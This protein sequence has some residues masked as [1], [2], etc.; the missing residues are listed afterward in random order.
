MGTRDGPS[1]VSEEGG[2]SLIAAT[3]KRA[4]EMGKFDRDR[5]LSDA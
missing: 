3:G 1:V 4:Q 5:S 2:A